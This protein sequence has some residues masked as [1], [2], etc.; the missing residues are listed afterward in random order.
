MKNRKGF[1]IVLGNRFSCNRNEKLKVHNALLK[2]MEIP[3]K[4]WKMYASLSIRIKSKAP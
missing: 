2:R 3:Y 4:K 1:I